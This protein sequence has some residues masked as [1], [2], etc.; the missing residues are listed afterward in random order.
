MI[1]T[2][3]ECTGFFGAAWLGV[4]VVAALCLYL[5]VMI[6]P[7]SVAWTVRA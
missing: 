3:W 2:L 5:Y 4:T 1:R 7:L 6:R